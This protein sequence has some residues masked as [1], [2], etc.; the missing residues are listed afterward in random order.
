MGMSG[1]S[2]IEERA[3]RFALETA[4]I[5]G[6]ATAKKEF[7]KLIGDESHF[8]LR[9]LDELGYLPMDGRR[10]NLFFQLVA[11][12]YTHGSLLITS[13]VPFDGWGK[14]F[15]DEVLASAI[16]DRLL[17]QSHIFAINGPSFRLKDK[18]ASRGAP[19]LEEPR[20]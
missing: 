19:L 8:L 20:S 10:A 7:D 15:G 1:L 12:R 5:Q 6:R 11:A 16:L 18:L 3:V 2:D 9:R 13:N 4:R 17:H 14:L